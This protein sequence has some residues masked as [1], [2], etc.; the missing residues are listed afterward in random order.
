MTALVHRLLPLAILASVLCGCARQDTLMSL[1]QIEL[2][3]AKQQMLHRFDI[4]CEKTCRTLEFSGCIDIADK[5]KRSN[6]AAILILRF[7]DSKGNICELSGLPTTKIF[8]DPAFFRY[9]PG[10]GGAKNFSGKVPIPDVATQV[11]IGLS[12]FNN[13]WQI[14]LVDFKCAITRSVL[15]ALINAVSAFCVENVWIVLPMCGVALAIILFLIWKKVI[16]VRPVLQ[17]VATVALFLMT[18]VSFAK[19]EDFLLPVLFSLATIYASGIGNMVRKMK[20]MGKLDEIFCKSVPERSFDVASTNVC[21]GVAI[22]LMLFHHC[23]AYYPGRLNDV[24]R[25]LQ[26]GGKICVAIF[27]LLSGF[28]LM[29]VKLRGTGFKSDVFHLVKLWVNFWFLAAIWILFSCLLEGRGF[30]QVYPKGWNPQFFYDIS[31]FGWPGRCF[32]ATWWFMGVI[33]PL[34]L[35]FPF[36][37]FLC[38]K[39]WPWL[40]VVAACAMSINDLPRNIGVW[41]WAFVLGMVMAKGGFL[42]NIQRSL[43]YLSAAGLL[44]VTIFVFY[45]R[46]RSSFVPVCEGFIALLIVLGVYVVNSAFVVKVKKLEWVLVFLGRHSM[47]IFLIHPYFH[48]YYL[49]PLLKLSPPLEFALV[50]MASLAC[51]VVVEMLKTILGVNWAMGKLKRLMA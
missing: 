35:A 31:G 43:S 11:E 33:V 38:R 45:F 25:S 47:N 50:L 22:C 10:G 34:Y 5:T 48:L 13:E 26:G 7:F 18:L 16:S 17:I 29:R 4:S 32:C 6:S 9:L 19:S 36:L 39:S 12:R 15:R 1:P 24:G 42:E 30:A 20:W 2:P 41:T 44:V 40:L 3:S 46:S 14:K 23:F 21:K 8:K 51:S 49:K 27:C 28:G 37:G